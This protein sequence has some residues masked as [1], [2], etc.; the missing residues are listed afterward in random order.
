M[1]S[2]IGTAPFRIFLPT[3][4][5][6]FQPAFSKTQS[7][8][9]N[10]YIT[11][12]LPHHYHSTTNALMSRILFYCQR[13]CCAIALWFP[14]FGVNFLT[15][16]AIYV[17]LFKLAF[18][19]YHGFFRFLFATT[20]TFFYLM[21]T[22]SYYRTVSNG[23][24]SP[25]DIPGFL[26]R[27]EDLEAGMASPPPAVFNNVTAKDNGEMRFCSKCNCW[28][29]DRT[30]HCRSCKKCILRMDHHCPWF[31]SCIGFRNHK[32]F[33]QFLSYVILLCL[34]CFCAS[35]WALVRYF[36][37]EEYKQHYPTLSWIAL[38]L[39]SGVMGLAVTAFGGYS[40]Y[41]VFTNQTTL[42]MMEAVRYKSSIPSQEYRF[43]EAP[44]S[45]SVGNIFD[46]GWR[47]NWCELMGNSV[48]EWILPIMNK[49]MSDGTSFPIN[50]VL[51]SSVQKHADH[52]LNAVQQ[53]RLYLAHQRE[54]QRHRIEQS[55]HEDRIDYA[56][57]S[58]NVESIPLTSN[59]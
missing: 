52:E 40:I 29:P 47:D 39:T 17:L 57:P 6:K 42:E 41:L 54:Q 15:T 36:A 7:T 30:H 22:I 3:H 59:Y 26:V 31:S 53:Q 45:R 33:V 8:I 34:I 51:W 44:D 55:L 27:V 19:Y 2:G 38:C 37:D 5:L 24:A 18:S 25:L 9:K 23:G 49:N 14:R 56:A 48:I 32:F 50:E 20:G 58:A 13:F 28:K 4:T 11:T 21:C 16:W 43:Q 10:Q 46:L 35:I 1:T 12:P